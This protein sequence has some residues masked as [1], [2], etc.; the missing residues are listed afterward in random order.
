MEN[1]ELLEQI[2]ARVAQKL[3]EAGETVTASGGTP[4]SAVDWQLPGL[5][6]LTQEHG[7]HCHEVLES[8]RIR[9]CYQTSCA[10]LQDYQ[11]DLDQV[12]VVVLFN[13][14]TDA[15]CKIA[16]GITD[17]P[18]TS[19]VAKALLMGKKL[20]VPVEEVELSRYPVRKPGSFQCMLQ[21]K[22]DRL[23]SWGLRIC[24]LAQLEDCILKEAAQATEGAAQCEAAAGGAAKDKAAAPCGPCS[25]EHDGGSEAEP[26]KE[27][28]FSKKVITERDVIEA[29]RDNVKVI[30]VTE[31]NIVTALARDAASARNIRIVRK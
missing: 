13:L 8:S 21:T 11:V 22:L 27:M 25:A 15:M 4:Q 30:C 20:F 26:E 3:A 18:Y 19:L 17:T 1:K 28:T 23:V 16:S 9:E 29:N 31:R 2:V 7:C 24:P 10:L 5:L 6:I 14:T 12:E